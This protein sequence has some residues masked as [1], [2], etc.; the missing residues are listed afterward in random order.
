[1]QPT[2]SRSDEQEDC[3]ELRILV[4]SVRCGRGVSQEVSGVQLDTH[5]EI[6]WGR[7]PGVKILLSRWTAGGRG[8]QQRRKQEPGGAD[9]CVLRWSQHVS[10]HQKAQK[11]T[12]LELPSSLL[13]EHLYL[14]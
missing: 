13:A 6:R 1:M 2:K 9:G 10:P 8:G 12:R 11:G 5:L 4:L 3:P 14:T 7:G